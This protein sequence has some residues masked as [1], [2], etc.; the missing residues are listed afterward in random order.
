MRTGNCL[1]RPLTPPALS[2]LPPPHAK[3][4]HSH[5]A[6]TAS[7]GRAARLGSVRKTAELLRAGP[8]S[9]SLR[10]SPTPR[11]RARC[12]LQGKRGQAG[13]AHLCTHASPSV[14]RCHRR[15]SRWS[16]PRTRCWLGQE[17]GRGERETVSGGVGG[18]GEHADEG[19]GRAGKGCSVDYS[20][21]FRLGS[22]QLHPAW[23]DEEYETPS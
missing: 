19:V 17:E 6:A 1:E 11:G 8:T 3:P 7:V 20:L 12:A 21:P 16:R 2:R 18:R 9:H 10:P 23:R 4:Q 13:P 15:Q 5:G 22:G 14:P